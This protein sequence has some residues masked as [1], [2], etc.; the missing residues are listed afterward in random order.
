LFDRLAALVALPR[1]LA[2]AIA[3]EALAVALLS[4]Q[5]GLAWV[6]AYIIAFGVA[7]GAMAPLRGALIA[8]LYGRRAYGTI[9]AAQGVALAVAGAAGP[10]ALGAVADHAGYGAALWSAVA[11]LVLGAAV[12]SIAAQTKPAG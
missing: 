2:G 7:Y 6:L 10:A 11:A 3:L 1:L 4:A 5:R 8:S 9:I 12:A